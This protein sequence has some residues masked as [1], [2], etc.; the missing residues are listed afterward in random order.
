[1]AGLSDGPSAGH[2]PTTSPQTMQH[3]SCA[4]INVNSPSAGYFIPLVSFIPDAEALRG[5][6][7]NT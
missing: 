1:M 2:E 3:K 5:V 7:P 6:G 4:T